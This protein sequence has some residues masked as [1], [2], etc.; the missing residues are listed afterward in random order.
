M[1]SDGRS[2]TGGQGRPPPHSFSAVSAFFA[3]NTR[4]ALVRSDRVD[5]WHPRFPSSV[6]VSI[7][8]LTSAATRSEVLHR[9]RRGHREQQAAIPSSSPSVISVVN[10]C[11]HL[12][13]SAATTLVICVHLRTSVVP[14]AGDP[15]SA[16][17]QANSGLMNGEL[18]K[19]G[20]PDDRC[21]S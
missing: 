13:P 8:L 6:A 11:I 9:E 15:K 2:Q 10:I 5:P 21:T 12:L 4:V 17:T 16:D 19:S 1:R 14:T 20:V 18:G 7:R 3:V